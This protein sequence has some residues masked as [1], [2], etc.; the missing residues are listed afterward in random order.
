MKNANK[1]T[2]QHAFAIKN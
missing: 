2:K 1:D